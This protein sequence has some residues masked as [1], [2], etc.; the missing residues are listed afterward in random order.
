MEWG[1]GPCAVASVCIGSGHGGGQ[2]E[3]SDRILRPRSS[4]IAAN[5]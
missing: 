1:V 2:G 4:T 3:G 5:N